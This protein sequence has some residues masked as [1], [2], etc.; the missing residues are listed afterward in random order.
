[1]KKIYFL[2]SA[3][4]VLSMSA[5]SQLI[6]NTQFI[7]PCGGDE[8]NEFIV[9]K[10]ASLQVSIGDICFGSYNPSTN[11]NGVGGNAIKDYNYWWAG[12]N[13]ATSPYPTFSSYSG[14]SCGDGLSCYGFL[15][16][17]IS[18]DNAD[19]NKL[20]GQLNTT[21]GCNV[22]IAVP[23]TNIIPANSNVI[24]FLGAGYRGNVGLC[25]FDNLSSNLNFSNHCSGNAPVTT[26]YVVFGDGNGAG[27]NCSNT[28]G[29]YFSNSSKRVS[30]LHVYNGGSK[31]NAA[32]Y[33]TSLQEYSPGGSG[34]AG[35]AGLIIPDGTGGTNWIS[36]KGCV[37]PPN[38][39]LAIKLE[40]FK[41]SIKFKKTTL[42]W[43]SAFEQDVKLFIVEKSINGKNFYSLKTVLPSNIS[44]TTYSIDDTALA[45]GNNFYRLRIIHQNETTDFSSI[46]KLNYTKGTPGNWALYPNPVEGA[47]FIDYR[48]L[49]TKNI[50]INVLDITGKLISS[51]QQRIV[52]GLNKVVIDASKLV[53]AMYILSI[54]NGDGI[55]TATFIKK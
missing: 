34:G 2:I 25:G 29:G 31:T 22:F 33:T 45:M 19:I 20:I 53:P 24:I 54:K 50:Q 13:T 16:P 26:Y 23:N 46:V 27:V 9:A 11:S 5:K 12:S 8:H 6:L 38:I 15:Y 44:G 28:T 32:N 18:A 10:T 3:V 14:E 47:A 52:T 7:N 4:L 41:G 48:S 39:I 21:A 51:K 37:P 17:S 30:A 36:N 40:Y 55:E 1:M 35:N 42:Q 43:K 49:T